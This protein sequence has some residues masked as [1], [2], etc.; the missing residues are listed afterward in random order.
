MLATAD[1]WQNHPRGTNGDWYEPTPL[2][3]VTYAVTCEGGV[4]RTYINGM[5]DQSIPLEKKQL[6]YGGTY[7][8]SK[9]EL[10]VYKR[11]L[12]SEE[13]EALVSQE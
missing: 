10:R 12:L 6:V 1:S 13:V 7:A 2:Q 8:Y 5:L 9:G 11:A 4:L 3:E